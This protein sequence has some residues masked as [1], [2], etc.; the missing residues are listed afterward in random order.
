M[1]T[2]RESIH[3][4]FTQSSS[5][6]SGHPASSTHRLFPPPR[7]APSTS[8]APAQRSP[9]SPS[10]LG[11][12]AAAKNGQAPLDPPWAGQ[13]QAYSLLPRHSLPQ[14]HPGGWLKCPRSHPGPDESES[15][16]VGH[17]NLHLKWALQG[18]F[19]NVVSA[20][21]NTDEGP[22]WGQ[23]LDAF[24]RT[25][26]LFNLHQVKQ[27]KLNRPQKPHAP[28]QSPAPREGAALLTPNSV[29]QSCQVLN[30]LCTELYKH[31][32][33]LFL[34]DTVCEFLSCCCVQLSFIYSYC[35]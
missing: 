13:G 27:Q 20:C 34:L 14:D 10:T 19:M 23:V 15:L 5:E 28:F 21:T 26:H 35:L 30:C 1:S 25:T 12:W 32:V 6:S 7:P 31:C 17:R 11:L 3:C 8:P 29:D 24:S 2:A 16:G 18:S 33:R 4:V 22:S 9:P